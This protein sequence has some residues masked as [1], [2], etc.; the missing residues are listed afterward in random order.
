M[1][2]ATWNLNRARPNA[3]TRAK[4]LRKGMQHVNADVWVLTETHVE[5][6]PG[7]D[8]HLLAYS[9]DAPDR[10]AERGEC[11]VAIW[12]R[13]GGHSIQLTADRERVAAAMISD[14]AV[15]G[16]VLPWLS[17]SRDPKLSGGALFCSKLCE[18]AEDWRR[19]RTEGAFCVAGDF[20]QDLLPEGRYYGSK[21]GRD[22]LRKTLS[23]CDLDCLTGGDD[24]PLSSAP[25][26]ANIDHICVYRMLSVKEPRS[27]SW[28]PIGQLNGITD[29]YCIYVD[30]EQM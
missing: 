14:C 25:G 10:N 27:S 16:T 15:V 24:D 9:A 17:D 20:N 1:R 29:H 5:F 28:P 8:F 7:S 26:K 6:S 11:W 23:S 18:Q 22:A 2:L 19:L 21:R 13:L 4:T 30:I 3:T 12:S